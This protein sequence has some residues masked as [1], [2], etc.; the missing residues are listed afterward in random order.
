[1]NIEALAKSRDIG[2]AVDQDIQQ[3][4]DEVGKTSVLKLE[5]TFKSV[6]NQ[7]ERIGISSASAI[8]PTE[9]TSILSESAFNSFVINLP[10]PALNVKNLQLLSANIPQAQVNI[11]DNALVFWYY[12]LATQN[13]KWRLW[14][15]TTNYSVGNLVTNGTRNYECIAP[16]T[17]ISPPNATY[18]KASPLQKFESPNL[19]NLHC[20][21]LLPSFYKKEMIIDPTLYG[22]NQTF[23]SYEDLEAE[24]KKACDNPDLAFTGFGEVNDSIRNDLQF[25]P[26]LPGIYLPQIAGDISIFYDKKSN[27]FIF[28]GNNVNY[29]SDI[30]LNEFIPLW[31]DETLYPPQSLVRYT[32]PGRTETI[33]SNWSAEY[34]FPPDNLSPKTSWSDFVYSGATVWNTY[35]VAG[36]NDPNILTLQGETTTLDWNPYHTFLPNDVGVYYKG[37]RWETNRLVRGIAPPSFIWDDTTTYK[38]GDIVYYDALDEDQSGVYMALQNH[39][40]VIPYGNPAYWIESYNPW[41]PVEE[42]YE[43]GLNY[44]SRKFDMPYL[45]NIGQPYTDTSLQTTL[46]NQ[47]L[48]R[49]LGFTWNGANMILP[50]ESIQNFSIGSLVTL[51][52]NRLRPIPFYWSAVVVGLEDP[53]VPGDVTTYTADAFCNLVYSSIINVYTRILGGSTTDSVRNTNLLA[54]VPLNCGNLGVTFT[55]NFIDNPLTKVDTD[56]YTIEFLFRTETDQPY[57]F[58]NNAILTFQLKLGYDEK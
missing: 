33:Y 53:Y 49:V 18:W 12:R 57:W 52:Y 45:G 6:F 2:K 50:F 16:N 39:S 4:L 38:I 42:I 20:V 41:L 11:Q 5:P 22:Y 47:I 36:Y 17:N 32:A 14:D 51:F 25:D 46:N 44:I 19:F 58:S 8:T 26:D 9:F 1:M 21:R 3:I 28:K 30:E 56:I 37:K 7:P 27:K 35:L 24:L 15:D 48:N 40:G 10:R 31:D 13:V 43:T 23:D 29:G 34:Q 54:I 55:N